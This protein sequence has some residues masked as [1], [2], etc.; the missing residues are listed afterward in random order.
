MQADLHVET[1]SSDAPILSMSEL[2][3]R[4][5][6]GDNFA[7]ETV[8]MRDFRETTPESGCRTCE[9]QRENGL[10]MW[11]EDAGARARPLIKLMSPDTNLATCRGGGLLAQRGSVWH[12]LK[13]AEASSV[14]GGLGRDCDAHSDTALVAA[15]G[16]RPLVSGSK[17][18][19]TSTGITLGNR[20]EDVQG[21]MFFNP[22]RRRSVDWRVL[23]LAR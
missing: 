20:Y 9:Q 7:R 17:Y 15:F 10:A 13:G 21:A 1:R 11:R 23:G 5:M 19:C 4:Y 6:V 3:W 12:L 18:L 16:T 14:S 2:I 8:L 22:P